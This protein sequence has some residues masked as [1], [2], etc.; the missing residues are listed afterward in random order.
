MIP[1]SGEYCPMILFWESDSLSGSRKIGKP[2]RCVGREFLQSYN[3]ISC[4]EK[5]FYLLGVHMGR[6]VLFAE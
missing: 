5:F 1:V 6:F 2:T 3:K 4:Y